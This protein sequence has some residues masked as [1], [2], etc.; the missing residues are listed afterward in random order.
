M[1]CRTHKRERYPDRGNVATAVEFLGSTFAQ[2]MALAAPPSLS[3][4]HVD[5]NDPPSDRFDDRGEHLLY[6]SEFTRKSFG[7]WVEGI[8]VRT[9]VGSDVERLSMATTNELLLP[10]VS[11]NSDARNVGY[12]E[13][14][15]RDEAYSRFAAAVLQLRPGEGRVVGTFGSM[16]E[17]V[18]RARAGAPEAIKEALT[19]S[20]ADLVKVQADTALRVEGSDEQQAQAVA[21]NALLVGRGFINQIKLGSLV[22]SDGK[23]RRMAKLSTWLGPHVTK[24]CRDLLAFNRNTTTLLRMVEAKDALTGLDDDELAEGVAAAL[25][26]TSVKPALTS[27]CAVPGG[28]AARADMRAWL[29]AWANNTDGSEAHLAGL[30][31]QNFAEA[32]AG[33]EPIRVLVG[34]TKAATSMPTDAAEAYQATSAV[35][36]RVGARQAADPFGPTAMAELA[37]KVDHLKEMMRTEPWLSRT[38]Q[39]RMDHVVVMLQHG[40]RAEARSLVTPAFAELSLVDKPEGAQKRAHGLGAVPKHYQHRLAPAQAT[41]SYNMIKAAIL[42]RLAKGGAAADLDALQIAATGVAVNDDGT[43]DEARWVPLVQMMAEGGS[44]GLQADLVD[45]DLARLATIA[46]LSLPELV[47]R[48]VALQLSVRG[49][50]L[51]EKLVGFELREVIAATTG[52]DYSKLDLGASYRKARAG[53]REGEPTESTAK[54]YATKSDCQDAL[55]V[56]EAVLTLRGF[57]GRG[58]DTLPYILEQ[59]IQTWELY[60]GEGC[61]VGT[62]SKLAKHGAEYIHATLKHFG[63]LRHAMLTGR[64]PEA[65]RYDITSPLQARRAFEQHVQK[66]EGSMAVT[67]YIEYGGDGGAAAETPATARKKKEK[68][69]REQGGG[70]GAGPSAG[71]QGWAVAPDHDAKVV[72]VTQGSEARGTYAFDK[73]NDHA[74]EGRRACL[75]GL[76]LAGLRAANTI[77]EEVAEAIKCTKCSRSAAVNSHAWKEGSRLAACKLKKGAATAPAAATAL[78]KTAAGAGKTRKAKEA[79]AEKEPADAEMSDDDDG[80]ATDADEGEPSE[81]SAGATSGSESGSSPKPKRP[82]AKGGGKPH[83]GKGKG[84]Q[85][86]QRR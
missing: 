13:V 73:L 5:P 53:L 70:A 3:Y 64:D 66:L 47:G 23:L 72:R 82:K 16:Y 1:D 36:L 61:S 28:A 38:M 9:V 69:K 56:A 46:R 76:V 43:C 19:L 14:Y 22:A 18:C 65:A 15:I 35:A 8:P 79:E 33:C 83:A 25:A 59:V 6:M 85:G 24:A 20:N 34:C 7:D 44:R 12:G 2:T 54:P 37:A 77:S 57:P 55:K 80:D 42:R 30:L 63:V 41:T 86:F 75:R 31:R 71:K 39:E 81:P 74:L 60:G 51:P 48:A 62:L 84:G 32:A 26:V 67:G 49:D 21:Y 50:V 10:H 68:R 52:E 78:A 29:T 17:E 11:L 58:K 45:T 4:K 27:L 40:A